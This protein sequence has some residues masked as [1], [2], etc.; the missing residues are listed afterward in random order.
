MEDGTGVFQW[1]V[2]YISWKDF[3]K[4]VIGQK[5]HIWDKIVSAHL[6]CGGLDFSCDFM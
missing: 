3:F 6:V 5:G 2:A 4:A 1:D